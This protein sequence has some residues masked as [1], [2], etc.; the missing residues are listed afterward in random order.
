MSTYGLCTRE[1]KE[2]II[3]WRMLLSTSGALSDTVEIYNMIDFNLRRIVVNGWT[4]ML[5]L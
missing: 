5:F 4:I 2:T 3:A 1:K